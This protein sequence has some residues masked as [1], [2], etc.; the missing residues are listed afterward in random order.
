MESMYMSYYIDLLLLPITRL[1]PLIRLQIR[2]PN[3]FTQKKI[4]FYHFQTQRNSQIYFG[5]YDHGKIYSSLT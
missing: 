4:D 5:S 2:Q 1:L 3:L